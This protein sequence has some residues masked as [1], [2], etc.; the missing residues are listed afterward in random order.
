MNPSPNLFLIG[1]T[2]A[3]KTSVG[4]RLAARLELPFLDLDREIETQTGVDVPTIFDIEGE[5]GFRQREAAML[6]ELSQRHPI[7]LATGAG[8]VLDADNRRRLAE[9]GFV[10]WLDVGVDQQIQRLQHDTQ[11][12][13]LASAD[14]RQRLLD[15]AL[16]RTPLYRDLA[17]LRVPGHDE[18]VERASERTLHL[19]DTHWARTPTHSP[20][21]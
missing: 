3:G 2:G 17:N 16:A 18:P 12:P 8:A 20:S 15:M 10:L 4:R 5:A 1:P 11:R 9:R 13:L 7:V 14:R 6:D 21:P 19:L